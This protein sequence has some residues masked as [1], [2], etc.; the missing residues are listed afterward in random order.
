MAPLPPGTVLVLDRDD[1]LSVHAAFPDVTIDLE[2]MDV[3]DADLAAADSPG[4]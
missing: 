4:G 1:W 2:P 3:A